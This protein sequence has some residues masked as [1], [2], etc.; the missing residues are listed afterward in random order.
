MTKVSTKLCHQSPRPRLYEIASAL[1]LAI[2]RIP[3]VTGR[4]HPVPKLAH[5]AETGDAEDMTVPGGPSNEAVRSLNS[6]LA[7]RSWAEAWRLLE[8]GSPCVSRWAAHRCLLGASGAH[9]QG[10]AAH[11]DVYAWSAMAIMCALDARASF[12]HAIWHDVGAWWSWTCHRREPQPPPFA[13]EGYLR[14][15]LPGEGVRSLLRCASDAEAA[16]LLDTLPGLWSLAAAAAVTVAGFDAARAGTP[17]AEMI[18]LWAARIIERVPPQAG[19][20]L[21]VPALHED[22]PALRRLIFRAAEKM[23]AIGR[24]NMSAV[25]AVQAWADVFAHPDSVD[26]ISGTRAGWPFRGGRCRAQSVLRRRAQ[27][28]PAACDRPAVHVPLAA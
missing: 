13:V 28:R 25:E 12:D 23:Q 4:A 20:D 9:G 10:E 27:P 14:T 3:G 16:G 1:Q 15:E 24:T 8:S 19:D 17:S 22:A 6:F 11:R 7:A 5:R 2:A 26:M 18:F 21:P